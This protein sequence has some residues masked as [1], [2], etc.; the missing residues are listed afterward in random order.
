MLWIPAA[1]WNR[2]RKLV[3]I[4][5]HK[6]APV[7]GEIPPVVDP[8]AMPAV[9]HWPTAATETEIDPAIGWGQ[10][11]AADAQLTQSDEVGAESDPK[12]PITLMTL[13]R[14]STSINDFIKDLACHAAKSLSTEEAEVHC[15]VLLVRPRVKAT[16]AGSS[17]RAI[18]M[19]EVQLQHDDGPCLRAART[20]A[21]CVVDDFRTDTRFGSYAD[22]IQHAGIRSAVGVPIPLDE[23]TIAALDLYSTQP[24][25]FDAD[26]IRV[27]VWFADQ[28]SLALHTAVRIARLDDT[29]KHLKLAM[30]T[31]AVIQVATGV[32]MAQNRC[33]HD[34]AIRILKAAASARNAK[35]RDVSAGLLHSIGQEP[36]G[37]HFDP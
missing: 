31:R 15:A 4:S 11:L 17:T 18:A 34:T 19:D 27:A 24:H 1:A 10:K 8:R 36:P 6:K 22:S 29:A 25:A 2:A 37:S 32:I 3:V 9:D 30:D 20:G 14:A 35:L 12:H 5:Y 33:S 23:G 16:M 28:L 21:L 13:L 26:R 7:A